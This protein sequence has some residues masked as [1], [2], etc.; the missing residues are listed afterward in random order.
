MPLAHRVIPTFLIKG[1]SLV[2][3]KRF[4]SDRVIG[5]ALQAIKV[6]A[7]REVDEMVLLDVTATAEG[8]GPNLALVEQLTDGPLFAPL[9]VGGGIRSLKDVRDVLRAGADKV[10]VGAASNT[11]LVREIASVVG[12]QA[13]MVSIDVRDGAVWMRNGSVKFEW[14]SQSAGG[15]LAESWA[16]CMEAEFAGEILLQSIDRDGTLQGYDLDLIRAVRKA[17]RVPIIASGGCGTYEHMREAIEAGASAVAAGAMFAFTDQTPRGAAR[18]LAA[19][20]IEARV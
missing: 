2:K 1:E 12:S 16:A 7:A 20:G 15:V 6:Q 11:E 5:H 19:H 10:V 9:A 13:V 17:V 8:R 4:A 3:G 14:F 18:Y